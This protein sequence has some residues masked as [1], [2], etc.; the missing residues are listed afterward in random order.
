VE[1]T[2]ASVELK[3]L[4]VEVLREG[5]KVEPADVDNVVVGVTVELGG[6]VDNNVV[7]VEVETP[8][9]KVVCLGGEVEPSVAEDVSVGVVETRV[10][11]DIGVEVGAVDGIGFSRHVFL[12]SV[13]NFDSG[14]VQINSRI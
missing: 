7:G 4:A 14:Q 6:F 2:S 3:T 1:A 10:A 13:S 9:L 8:D 11:E 5:M 12:F